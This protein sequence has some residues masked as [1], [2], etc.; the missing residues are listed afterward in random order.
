MQFE[1]DC[2][3]GCPTTIVVVST[4][5]RGIHNVPFATVGVIMKKLP[6][7]ITQISYVDSLK[8]VDP[9]SKCDFATLAIETKSYICGRCGGRSDRCDSDVDAN[10][11]GEGAW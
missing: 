11:Y 10:G 9:V 2:W 3:I 6:S 4:I 1:D 8:C 7:G 5:D